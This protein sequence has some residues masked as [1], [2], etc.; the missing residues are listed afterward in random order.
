MDR[1]IVLALEKIRFEHKLYQHGELRPKYNESQ[2]TQ[3]RNIW[4][5][6]QK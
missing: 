6:L 1:K 2:R 4:I 5:F 3:N